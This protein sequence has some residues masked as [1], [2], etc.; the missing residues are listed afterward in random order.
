MSHKSRLTKQDEEKL[1]LQAGSSTVGAV[2]DSKIFSALLGMELEGYVF[3]PIPMNW[4]ARVLWRFLDVRIH[5]Q[6]PPQVFDS[7]PKYPWPKEGFGN[8]RD[9]S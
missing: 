9:I 1:H 4:L 6:Q 2:I 5:V 7:M 3:K 8:I